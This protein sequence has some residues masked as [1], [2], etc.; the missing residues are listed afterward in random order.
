[1]S[2]VKI[3]WS[4]DFAYVIGLL[5]TDGSLSSDGRHIS[6]TS[7]D[8]ELVENVNNGLSISCNFGMK[9]NGINKEKKY[10]VIQIGD[11]LF[12]KFL[13]EIG[14]MPNK[15]KILS[16]IKIPNKYFFDFLRGHFDGDGSFYSYWDK[17]WKNSFMFY[18][19]FASASKKHIYW[20]Q[21]KISDFLGVFGHITLASGKSCYQL[22]YAKS[23]SMK[24]VR[25]MYKGTSFLCLRRKHLKIFKAFAILKSI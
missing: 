7:K 25:N 20:L 4:R 23:E 1:M 14:L 6:F 3:K 19:S 5:T 22:K 10:F 9:G 8:K 24:I 16:G 2:K 18:L 21:H 12:Y 17:R 15:T 13:M 11:V